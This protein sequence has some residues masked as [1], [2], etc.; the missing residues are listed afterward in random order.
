[1]MAR[2]PLLDPP[3]HLVAA[4]VDRLVRADPSAAHFCRS[5]AEAAEAGWR[6]AVIETANQKPRKDQ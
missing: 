4:I 1:M 3:P 2:D 5:L 6:Q